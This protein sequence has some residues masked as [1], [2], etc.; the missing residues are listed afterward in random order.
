MTR[1]TLG[2]V[3][4]EW[5]CPKCGSRNPGPE[6]V[7]GSC[8][9]AQPENVQFQQTEHQELIKDQAAVE[10]AK[11]GPDTHCAFCGTRN[12]AGAT[13]CSQCGADLKS[14]TQRE[15]GR[16]VGSFSTGPVKQVACPNCGT[17]NPETALKCAQCGASM[18]PAAVPASAPDAVPAAPAKSAM[19]PLVI[20]LAV[21]AGVVCLAV[22]I[23][24][25]AMSTSTKDYTGVVESA[26]WKTSIVIEALLPAKHQGWQDELPEDAQVGTCTEKVHH[27]QD[28]P[29]PNSNKVCGTP[30][31]VDKGSGYAEVVQD[32]QY[33]VLQEYCDYSVMEWQQ[34]DVASLSGTDFSPTW[35][36]P[37]L[38]E[39][40]RLGEQAEEYTIVF[41]TAQG[42]YIYTTRDLNEYRQFQMGSEWTLNINGFGQVVSVE[43]V[44]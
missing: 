36:N 24:F 6:K 35:P 23:F 1:E 9:A 41:E 32:C 8:G 25:L 7:C 34:E 5:T 44:K 39:K 4:L 40:Q 14:G 20:G 17:M 30:Y 43:P 12:P 11:T 15:V 33:E 2:Y 22:I 10:Q 21:V 28:Q 18:A 16:V 27:V 13:V 42:Q 3:K 29:A 37:Q 26:Q 19:S 31:T 38:S